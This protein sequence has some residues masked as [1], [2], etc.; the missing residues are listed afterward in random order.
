ME[1]FNFEKAFRRL[2]EITEI[3]EKNQL[4]L[5]ESLKLY[6]E[7]MILKNKCF[8]YLQK[9]EGKLKIYNFKKNDFEDINEDELQK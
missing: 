4:P 2:E 6:E 1:N 3:L 5:E 9:A 8:D 7:A